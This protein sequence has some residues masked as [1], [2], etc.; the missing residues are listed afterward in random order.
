MKTVK[1][2]RRDEQC[3]MVQGRTSLGGGRGHILNLKEIGELRGKQQRGG[4]EGGAAREVRGEPG[5]RVSSEP[6]RENVSVRERERPPTS[7]HPAATVKHPPLGPSVVH[8]DPDKKH[9]KESW[10]FQRE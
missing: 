4:G 8:C 2:Q 3:G 10:G 7:H 9:S 6:N 5:G 1:T